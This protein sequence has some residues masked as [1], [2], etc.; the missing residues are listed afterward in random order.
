[1]VTTDHCLYVWLGIVPERIERLMAVA[2]QVLVRNGLHLS[3]AG[4]TIQTLIKLVDCC[5]LSNNSTGKESH[6]LI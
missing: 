1:M 6:G 3:I 4:Q 5:G 2:V